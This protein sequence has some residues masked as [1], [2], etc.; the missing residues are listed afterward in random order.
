MAARARSR[1]PFDYWPGFVDVLSTLLLVITFMLSI[2]MLGQYFLG[3]QLTSRDATIASLQA[4]IA[5]LAN[6]LG[7]VQKSDSDKTAE[8]EKLRATLAEAEARAAA[9]AAA[10]A[11]LEQK[12][13]ALSDA[14]AQL[15]LLNQQVEQLRLQL[16]ALQEALGASE[17]K[18][19]DAQVQIDDLGRRLNEALA[20]KVKELADY[21]S[22]FFGRLKQI[23]GDRTDIKI[24]GDRF[25]FQS[26]VLFAVNSADL[27]EQARVE[28]SV[29]AEA[30]KEIIP[31]IPEDI[32]WVLRVDGHSDKRPINTPAFPSNL[33]LSSARAMSV[34]QF[35]IAM[36]V[37]ANHL[38]ATGFGDQRPIDPGD[39]DEA[40]AKN[41][42]I[43]FKL[44]EP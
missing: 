42:R 44:T 13:Q 37:P 8:L 2:F 9:G 6:Q 36:G 18:N 21:R 23:L 1:G 33:A 26:E 30:L 27:S 15:A 7:L 10:V 11:E 24:S 16:L 43:E 38:A 40:Y 34:V 22:E 19:K 35:L 41:R 31:Q 29:L 25:V 14:E 12:G 5:D 4:R 17:A 39:S 3:Q 20:E 32:D 28:L